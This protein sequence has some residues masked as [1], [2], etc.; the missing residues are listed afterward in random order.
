M[1]KVYL[2]TI[3]IFLTVLAEYY[4][5]YYA[6]R[7]MQDVHPFGA[8]LCV[9][10][11]QL[12]LPAG[13]QDTE[14]LLLPYL[15]LASAADIRCGEIPYVSI[16]GILCLLPYPFHL[17]LSGILFTLLLTVPASIKEYLGWG[18]TQLLLVMS[19]A[20]GDRI[21]WVLLIASVSALCIQMIKKKKDTILRFGP[22]LSF[23]FYVMLFFH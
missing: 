5:V 15:Y 21:P 13:L 2:L 12:L 7:D 17:S 8:V 23:A 19:A 1:M 18:D 6:R 9:F 4:S 16:L 10:A 11:L 14:Y 20:Y 3:N 22:Y